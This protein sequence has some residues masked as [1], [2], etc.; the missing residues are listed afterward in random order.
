MDRPPTSDNRA[1]D[2]MG[3]EHA[4]RWCRCC[5]CCVSPTRCKASA[6]EAAAGSRCW[7]AART[8]ARAAADTTWRLQFV[9]ASVICPQRCSDLCAKCPK[10]TAAVQAP[11]YM[12]ESGSS[13]LQESQHSQ[14]H[15]PQPRPFLPLPRFAVVPVSKDR[16][17][18]KKVDRA[19]SAST[20]STAASRLS[21][22]DSRAAAS[23]T[24]CLISCR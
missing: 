1:G 8:R 15:Q 21:S 22:P 5:R 10:P 14:E 4:S 11:Q 9:A 12:Y 20:P 17:S 19:V 24:R 6:E 18:A 13:S 23:S 7:P 16:N 3:N 2:G